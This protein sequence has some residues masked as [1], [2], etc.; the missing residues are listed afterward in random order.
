MDAV[1]L[2]FSTKLSERLH[3][4]GMSQRELARLTGINHVSISRYASGTRS[5]NVYYA[6]LIAQALNC[7]VDELLGF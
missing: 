1:T 2:T 7:T 3:E 5:P 6:A 4:L